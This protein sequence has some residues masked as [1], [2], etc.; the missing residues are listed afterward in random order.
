M[1]YKRFGDAL[2][3]RIDKGEE[4]FEQVKEIA[5]KEKIRLASVQAIGAVG[6]FTAGVF[7]TKEKKFC[8]NNFNGSFE[9]VSLSGTIDTMQGEFYCHLHMSAANVNGEVF[10][11]HLSRAVVSATCEMIIREA[12]GSLDRRHSEE[13]G[14][15]LWE[16]SC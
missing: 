1:E 7:D 12:S 8:P 5:I 14:L 6:E 13:V 3:A 9:I 15:N 11:G 2:F 4:I 16:F 10:G